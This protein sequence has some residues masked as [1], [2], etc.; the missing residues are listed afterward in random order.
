MS[1]PFGRPSDDEFAAYLAGE[2]G[3]PHPEAVRIIQDELER[4]VRT[5]PAECDCY[6]GGFTGDTYEGPQEDCPVHGRDA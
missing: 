6:P 5:P 2:S 4:A 3:P 1:E